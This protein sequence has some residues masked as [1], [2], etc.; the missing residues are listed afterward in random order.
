[1][2]GKRLISLV[3]CLCLVGGLCIPAPVRA[4]S[5]SEIRQDINKLEQEQKELEKQIQELESQ[6][7]ENAT[8]L[9]AIVEQKDILDQQISLLNQQILALEEQMA[10]QRQLIAQAQEE[11]DLAQEN[12]ASLNAQYRARI[13]AME[14]QGP[15]SYWS[16][17]FR[18]NSFSDFLDRVSM[19][20]EIA[21]ADRR[22]MDALRTAAQEVEARREALVRE[23]AALEEALAQQQAA[24][25]QLAQKQA[26]AEA[27]MLQLMAQA[28]EYQKLLD[29]AE[30]RE[31]EL[32]NE[33]AKLEHD[34]DRAAYLEWLATQPQPDIPAG[35]WLTPI[36][37]SYRLSSPFGMRIHP[38]YGTY[39]MHQ[40]IDMGCPG[41]T[42]IYASRGGQVSIAKYS[43]TAG[44]YV[45]INH[46]DG[47]RSVY[48]HMRYYTVRY[49]QFVTAGQVIG[50]VGST[51][52]STG[53][54]L[55]FG[56]SY[57]GEYINPYPLIPH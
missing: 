22:R 4:A 10:A 1:M 33:I 18:A 8:E 19:T 2:H 54:H 46:G 50:Y 12:Y 13:R 15:L 38:V 45:Q 25:D 32:L 42:P 27:V 24:R 28:E 55:H 37:A 29:E 14:E 26:Q 51:G 30:E 39:R 52:T 56:I 43:S 41:G 57:N 36:T 21:A 3:L 34:F 35:T 23:Q 31:Q 20:R 16:I 11:L 40:G 6:R 17:L 53:N 5:S 44:N 49:G 7:K 47:Y 9:K 48:M